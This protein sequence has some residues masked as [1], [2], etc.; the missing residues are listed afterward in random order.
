MS[1]YVLGNRVILGLPMFC[2]DDPVWREMTTKEA[3]THGDF[4]QWEKGAFGF[5]QWRHADGR[6]SS[7]PN[8][9]IRAAYPG[10]MP[11]ISPSVKG[12]VT[13]DEAYML[14]S[15]ALRYIIDRFGVPYLWGGHTDKGY[16]CSGVVAAAYD[17][18]GITKKSAGVF[19]APA[20]ERSLKKINKDDL[21]IGDLV[22]Y[23][24]IFSP[25]ATHVMMY[26]G[27]GK[28]VGATGGGRSTTTVEIANQQGAAIK[29]KPLDYRKDIRGYGQAPVGV[30]LK[31]VPATAYWKWAL[32]A[33]AGT[34]ALAGT[35]YGLINYIK[36][37]VVSSG[38]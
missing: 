25:G 8:Y 35:V 6:L 26:A 30:V 16:D 36:P 21:Q 24:S 9:S 1:D 31:Y 28:V 15:A 34:V 3:A 4:G 7:A 37:R 10:M 32:V 29:Q 12:E 14:R 19:N 22:F 2:P 33:G 18:A 38:A 11:V 27:E 13:A 17:A 20:W 5:W 23:G